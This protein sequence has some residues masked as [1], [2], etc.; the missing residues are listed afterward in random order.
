M[1]L[2]DNIHSIIT[3]ASIDAIAAGLTAES[4]AD[5]LRVIADSLSLVKVEELQA[6]RAE[7][8]ADGKPV[9][10]LA[11][12][13]WQGSALA[14][15]DY[16]RVPMFQKAARV[17]H[18][19]NR[20]L[21]QALGDNSQPAWDDAPEWQKDSSLAGVQAIFANPKTTSEQSHENWLAQKR[22]DGWK[23]GPMK[24]ADKKEHPC[25]VPYDQLPANLQLKDYLF[26]MVVRAVLEID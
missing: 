21:C 2:D 22:A 25:F 24:D 10:P 13:S 23:Y 4:V 6:E 20:I 5:D 15:I 9:Y 19:A 17:A 18:E 3:G 11:I 7:R 12:H 14:A 1:H 26:G 16:Q 8:L